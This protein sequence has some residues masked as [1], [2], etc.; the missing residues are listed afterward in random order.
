MAANAAEAIRLHT[1]NHEG[2]RGRGTNISIEANFPFL[3]TVHN[4]DA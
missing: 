2:L 1:V 4:K 3:G